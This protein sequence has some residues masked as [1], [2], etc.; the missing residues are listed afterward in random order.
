M[1][2]SYHVIEEILKNWKDLEETKKTFE[3]FSERYPNDDE[4]QK[5]FSEFQIYLKKKP[6]S[7]GKIKQKLQE[8]GNTRKLDSSGGAKDLPYSDRRHFSQEY[9]RA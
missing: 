9:E 6:G 4:L 5:I 8:L 1:L 7:L 3:K 2:A